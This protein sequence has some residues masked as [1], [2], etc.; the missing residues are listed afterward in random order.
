MRRATEF[1]TGLGWFRCPTCNRSTLRATSR[2]EVTT[3]PPQVNTL[4]QCQF[5]SRESKLLNFLNPGLLFFSVG[6]PLFA[7]TF[8]GLAFLLP[9][10]FGL[11]QFLVLAVAGWTVAPIAAVAVQRLIYRFSPIEHGDA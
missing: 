3:E 5:C 2:V 6:I 9:G 11:V 10:P 7:F 4:Y 8:C 1:R